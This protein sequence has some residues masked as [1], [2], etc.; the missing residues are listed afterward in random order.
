MTVR[1][2]GVFVCMINACGCVSL[3][4]I[5]GCGC[6]F[7][8]LSLTV[9][10][11]SPLPPSS[12]PPAQVL[13]LN[14]SEIE[15][16]RAEDLA[17]LLLSKPDLT[18]LNLSGNELQ[19][20][21]LAVV[22]A[23]LRNHQKLRSINLC[24]TALSSRSVATIVQLLLPLPALEQLSLDGNGF[25]AEALEDLQTAVEAAGKDF[26]AVVGSLSDNDEDFEAEDEDEEL[27]LAAIQEQLAGLAIKADE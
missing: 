12:Y 18:A 15:A 9:P 27:D 20:R 5:D 10:S 3:V 21:G 22:A 8:G 17:K 4:C 19:D 6:A 1:P 23:A 25:S 2:A 26:R 14:N 7:V 13:D 16:D 11:V 24:E